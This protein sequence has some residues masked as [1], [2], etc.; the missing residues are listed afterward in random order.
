MVFMYYLSGLVQNKF[1]ANGGHEHSSLVTIKQC[2]IHTD[3]EHDN[4]THT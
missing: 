4:H 1:K 2:V 3:T